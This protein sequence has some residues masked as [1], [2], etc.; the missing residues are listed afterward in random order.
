MLWASNWWRRTPTHQDVVQR[1]GTTWK[2]HFSELSQVTQTCYNIPLDELI[3][4]HSIIS[5]EMTSDHPTVENRKTA[6]SSKTSFDGDNCTYPRAI[7]PSHVQRP[8]AV[9]FM[10]EVKVM[11]VRNLHNSPVA[12]L[13]QL[14]MAQQLCLLVWA[15]DLSSS[16]CTRAT[17]S[18]QEARQEMHIA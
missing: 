5:S 11:Q 4:A 9:N 14:A 15:W 16:H 18:A 13:C 3:I 17:R 1:A 6:K 12:T 2:S 8:S 10:L 7:F